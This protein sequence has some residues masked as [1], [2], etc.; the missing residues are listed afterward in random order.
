MCESVIDAQPFQDVVFE[1]LGGMWQDEEHTVPANDYRTSYIRSWLNGFFYDIAFCTEEQDLI[2]ETELDGDETMRDKIFLLS[3]DDMTNPAYGFSASADAEDENRLFPNDIQKLQAYCACQGI[4]APLPFI[5]DQDWSDYGY[6]LRSAGQTSRETDYVT[7]TGTLDT[8]DADATYYGIRPAFRFANGIVSS[9]NPMGFYGE[10]NTEGKRYKT[11]D[12][13]Q[14][15][16]YPQSRVTD[17]DLIAELDLYPK[18]WQSYEYYSG[19]EAVSGPDAGTGNAV[20]GL[21]QPGDFMRYADI[22]YRNERYRAVIFDEYRPAYTGHKLGAGS[23]PLQYA[24]QY[25]KGSVYYFR[26]EPL[27]WR[28]LDPERG[29]MLC[30]NIIDAQAFQNTVNKT[31]NVRYPESYASNYACSSICEWLNSDFNVTAFTGA[32]RALIAAPTL[33]CE[34]ADPAN[35]QYDGDDCRAVF[36]LLSYADANNGAYGFD[37]NASRAATVTEYAKCQGVSCATNA[38]NLG[39]GTW[40]LRSPTTGIHTVGIGQDGAFFSSY[41]DTAAFM[42]VRPAFMFRG[43]IPDQFPEPEAEEESALGDTFYFGSYPQTLVT[44]PDLKAHL[45]TVVDWNS[46]SM[47]LWKNYRY[48][49][50]NDETHTAGFFY[51]MY[52]SDFSDADGERYRAVYF[53]RFRPLSTRETATTGDPDNSYQDDNGYACDTVYYFRYEPIKWRV[54]DPDTGLALCER[55]IDAQNYQNDYVY[56]RYDGK[57]YVYDSS[58]QRYYANNYALSTIRAWLNDSFYNTAFSEYE[59][60]LIGETTLDNTAP[61]T[62]YSCASTT[63]KIFLLSESDVKNAAYGFYE[64]NSYLKR[65]VGTDYAKCQGLRILGNYPNSDWLLRTAGR[66]SGTVCSEMYDYGVYHLA[67]VTEVWYGVRPAMCFRFASQL[68]S[69]RTVSFGSYPQTR[70]TDPATISALDAVGKIWQSYGYYSGS[71]FLNGAGALDGSMQ[72]GSWMRYA[73]LTS[74]GQKYRAVTFDVA[75]P[76]E[77]FRPADGS[78]GETQAQNG[79][80]SGKTYYFKY[81]PLQW[82]VTDE[83]QGTLLCKSLIDAQAYQNTVYT[84][85]SW[86]THYQS[87]AQTEYA[88]DYANSSLRQWLNSDFY[89]TAFTPEE[90]ELL[91]ARRLDNSAMPRT[92]HRELNY[93]SLETVDKVYLPSYTEAQFLF[94]NAGKGT[95]YAKCQGLEV[96]SSGRSAWWLRSPGTTSFNA[97]YVKSNGTAQTAEAVYRTTVG[98]RP[99]VTFANKLPNALK[100]DRI[101]FGGYPQ[102]EVTDGELISSLNAIPKDWVSYNYYSGTGNLYNGSMQP[103]DWMRFADVT[104][105]GQKYRAVTFD[106]PRPDRTENPTVPDPDGTTGNH[107][108]L[109]GNVYYFKFEPLVWRVL[110]PETGLVFC[111]SAIDAQPY[112]NRIL[113]W[114]EQFYSD[115]FLAFYANNYTASDIRK[116]LN[117]DF[118]FTAFSFDEQDMIADTQITN[119]AVWSN[120]EFDAAAC[121]DKIFLLSVDDVSN[122]IYG[123]DPNDTYHKDLY[124]Q[125]TDYADCQGITVSQSDAYAGNSSWWLRTADDASDKVCFV[126][127]GGGISGVS[128]TRTY[129]GIR[130]AFCFDGVITPSHNPDGGLCSVHKDGDGD[131]ICDVCGA[132]LTQIVHQPENAVVD[133]VGDTATFSV[134]ATGV[135]TYKWYYKDPGMDAFAEYPYPGSTMTF[136][137]TDANIGR[138]AYCVVTDQYGWSVSSDTV[139]VL[140]ASPFAITEHPTAV[141]ANENATATFTVTA[142]GAGLTYA[143]RYRPNSSA[144]WTYLTAATEGYNT[145]TLKITAAAALDGYRFQCVVQDATGAVKYSRD[146]PLTVVPSLA[147][148]THPSSVT[149]NENTTATFTVKAVGAGLTYAWRSRPDSSA[150]WTYLTADTEGYNTD[151]LKITAKAALNG[152]RFQCVVKDA[153]GAI[154]YSR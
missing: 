89:N 79:Y 8:C 147:I 121:T 51:D 59:Q 100:E 36:F 77:T 92:S 110:S 144:S 150:S 91:G 7:F 13:I 152:Y 134:T 132:D 57:Y 138:Q 71:G 99:A 34:A 90:K 96:T 135:V 11:G 24:N 127:A 66:G 128:V 6:R 21:M 80:E 55:L 44:D 30:E 70:V 112:H 85:S 10:L 123:F 82:V 117:K 58:Q 141:T 74:N 18:Y 16:S 114:N 88:N 32:Q 83:E 146:V 103:G 104:F 137:T 102:S 129:Y 12:L 67:S 118:F 19:T 29:L 5:E 56:D 153:S 126:N 145:D 98:V 116:W 130:P 105:E 139:R 72:S 143:W 9:Y 3:R 76:A 37:S 46:L 136:T 125:C 94:G 101:E 151:T 45:K 69:L 48:Y 41:L 119:N 50:W 73:D 65:A 154:K 107:G 4:G 54:L 42:G 26:Y 106:C 75:R 111:E 38:A 40:W 23:P 22:F 43:G 63:D 68:Q 131:C 87:S 52:Y 148:M 25:P 140:L 142:T 120:P 49:E 53:S 81:E 17:E 47:Y 33:Y 124:V 122:P 60:S 62:E 2:A 31:Q 97:A 149:A 86:S 133:K 84:A 61:D 64:D 93:N 39:N 1:N 14:L 108:Y 78:T 27:T 20:D 35:S 95:D 115:G 113:Y 28:V 15:G 109:C